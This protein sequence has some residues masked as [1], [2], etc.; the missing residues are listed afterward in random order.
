[1]SELLRLIAEH[2][3]LKWT[4]EGSHIAFVPYDTAQDADATHAY[5]VP[6]VAQDACLAT[7]R[8]S[9]RWT[10]PGGTRKTDETWHDALRRELLEETG[11]VIDEYEAFGAFQ[12]DDGRR[13]T[14]RIVCVAVVSRVQPAADPDGQ[15][16][17]IEV[18]EVPI[19]QATR[20]FDRDLV[21]Y[22]AVYM[23]AGALWTSDVTSVGRRMRSR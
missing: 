11:C 9:G 1:M 8:G 16:G 23:I 12:V 22:G 14:F 18:R 5:A 6:F 21:Q 10:L 2:P 20:L 17:I 3:C 13:K 19:A 4:S 7:Q 15:Q